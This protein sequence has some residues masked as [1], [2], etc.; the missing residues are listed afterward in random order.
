MNQVRD[1]PK[2]KRIF[3]RCY[4]NVQPFQFSIEW[5]SRN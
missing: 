5:S 2:F 1:L 4:W 3:W